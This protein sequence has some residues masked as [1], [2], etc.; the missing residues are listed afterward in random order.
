MADGFTPF[1]PY[2]ISSF[3]LELPQTFQSTDGTLQ[4]VIDGTNPTFTT[5]VVFRRVQVFRNGL[6]LTQNYDFAW[7]SNVVVFMGVQIPQ[8]GDILKVVGWPV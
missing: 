1:P 3:P 8:P 6:A 4:G 5:G 2:T 7:G